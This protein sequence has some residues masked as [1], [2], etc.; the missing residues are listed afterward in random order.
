LDAAHHESARLRVAAEEDVAAVR[1]FLRSKD[2][3]ALSKAIEVP[4][5]AARSAAIAFDLCAQ[6]APE[7]EGLL[8]ADLGAAAALLA[9][10]AKAIQVCVEANLRQANLSASS[11]TERS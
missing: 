7:V 2:S 6:A 5:R 3:A 11:E 4:E 8:A 1:E 9:G 10:A